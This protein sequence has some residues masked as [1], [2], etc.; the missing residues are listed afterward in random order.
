MLKIQFKGSV[1]TVTDPIKI[2]IE[3][4]DSNIPLLRKF[5]LNYLFEEEKNDNDNIDGSGELRSVDTPR[6]KRR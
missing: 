5:N 1:V 6:K 4:K 3:V 2:N